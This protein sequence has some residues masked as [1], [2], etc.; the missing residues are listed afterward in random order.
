MPIKMHAVYRDS[1]S[2]H[3]GGHVHASPLART[4]RRSFNQFNNALG[5]MQ[6]EAQMLGMVSRKRSVN[7]VP[8]SLWDLGYRDFGLD[9]AC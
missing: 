2:H 4:H 7:G 3:C 1:I 5:Q 8:T 9:D 6:L